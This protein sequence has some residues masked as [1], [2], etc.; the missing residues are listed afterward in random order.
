MN[1]IWKKKSRKQR[2][3]RKNSCFIF[4][5]SRPEIVIFFINNSV[6][7][8]NK[9]NVETAMKK[10]LI[11][12]LSLLILAISSNALWQYSEMIFTFRGAS[13]DNTG[14]ISV[15]ITHDGNVV[16]FGDINLTVKNDVTGSVPLIGS[17][18]DG[19]NQEV[20]LNNLTYGDVKATD[21]LKFKSNKIYT[22]GK[23]IITMSWPSNIYNDK[24]MFA[25][26]CPGIKCNDNYGCV[27]QQSC[28]NNTKICEWLDCGEG[29]VA[30]GHK[31]FSKCDDGDICTKDYYIEGQ[32]VNTKSENCCK[33]NKDCDA[34]KECIQNTCTS[35]PTNNP[36]LNIFQKVWRWLKHL[37]E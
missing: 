28:N 18:F 21:Y 29:G 2:R 24:I 19:S 22:K 34:S 32:C 4:T 7:Y 6:I 1:S 14:T 9:L 8:L 31:C 13:C 11:F 27:G 35:W 37:Y 12:V 30:N 23:Y 5:T 33:A 17:W 25:V 10:G 15:N 20:G 16:K 3:K 36:D 26:D